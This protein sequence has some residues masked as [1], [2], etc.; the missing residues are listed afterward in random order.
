M[1]FHKLTYNL[2]KQ[3]YSQESRSVTAQYG[4]WKSLLLQT[5][6]EKFCVFLFLKGERSSPLNLEGELDEE[7]KN[8]YHLLTEE[9]V[10]GWSLVGGKLF[11][12][13]EYLDL[14]KVR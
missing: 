4:E 12:D 8:V 9:L 11:D 2:L 5:N 13:L 6:D 7:Q 1:A 10:D 14:T 3:W